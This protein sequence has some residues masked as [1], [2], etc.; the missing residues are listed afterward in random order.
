MVLA[1]SVPK[2]DF[3]MSLIGG[4]LT[5]P[6]IFVFPPLFYIKMLILKCKHIGFKVKIE[7][8]LCGSI[9][10]FGTLITL[11]TTHKNVS[12]AFS[13]VLFVK[14]CILNATSGFV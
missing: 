12:D 14:P 9:A 13:Y 1:E 3:V 10:S 11:L 4:T 5:G 2:F 6:L 8:L 7:I